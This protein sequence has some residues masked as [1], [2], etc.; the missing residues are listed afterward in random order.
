MFIKYDEYELLE[1]FEQEPKSIGD[2]EAGEVIYS[3]KDENNFE[4]I[5]FM[6]VYQKNIELTITYFDRIVFNGKFDKVSKLYKNENDLI[7]QISGEDA[8]DIKFKKQL[9]VLMK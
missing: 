4:L 3:K 6:D 2:T 8:I 9:G 1:M 5:L 7:V